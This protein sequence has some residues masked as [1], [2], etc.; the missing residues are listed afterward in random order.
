MRCL[1]GVSRVC[2]DWFHGFSWVIQWSFNSLFNGIFSNIN[3][4]SRMF[5]GCFE[6]TSRVSQGYFKRVWVYLMCISW[7]FQGCLK[8]LVWALPP[9]PSKLG[10]CY[11]SCCGFEAIPRHFRAHVDIDQI[12][13]WAAGAPSTHPRN[14]HE[15]FLKQS[16]I[17]L[18]TNSWNTHEAPLK[19]FW[20]T[21]ETIL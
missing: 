6:G 10:P 21:Y 11:R 13:C 8:D 15:I 20:T 7:T 16:Q 19:H 4:I 14:I 12:T 2:E 3:N 17:K 5:C 1:K 18:V 9:P